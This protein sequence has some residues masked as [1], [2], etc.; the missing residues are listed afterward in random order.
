MFTTFTTHP[1][2]GTAHNINSLHILL[3]SPVT[4]REQEGGHAEGTV[5]CI[6]HTHVMPYIKPLNSYYVYCFEEQI[7]IAGD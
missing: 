4:P 7:C 1:L 2:A 3:C 5:A 6:E